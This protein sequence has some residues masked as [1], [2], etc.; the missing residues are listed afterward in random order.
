MGLLALFVVVHLLLGE[1]VAYAM[2]PPHTRTYMC[3]VKVAHHSGSYTMAWELSVTGTMAE[4]NPDMGIVRQQ[5][6][7]SSSN[8]TIDLFL[9]L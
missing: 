1:K 8:T 4:S 6:F 5:I 3:S 7:C 2:V 9:L